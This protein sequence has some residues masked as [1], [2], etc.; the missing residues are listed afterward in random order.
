[1]LRLVLSIWMV[2]APPRAQLEPFAGELQTIQRAIAEA[3]GLG[4]YY[5]REYRSVES[6][7]WQHIPAWM[8][9]DA[10]E[11]KVSRILDVG[12]GYGTLLSLATRIYSGAHGVCW[13]MTDYLKPAVAA[14]YGLAF[15]RGNAELDPIPEPP[16]DLI[17]LTE[18][19]EHFNF[20]PVP[21][22]RKL[23]DALSPGGKLVLSTPDAAQWG[24]L[25]DFY[26]RLEDIPPPRAGAQTRDRHTWMYNKDE[27]EGVL[28]QAGFRQIKQLE[29]ARGVRGRHFNIVAY[30]PQF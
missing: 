20:H 29:Y 12:C 4:G 14:R 26:R 28:K 21:T 7:W 22:L 16:Y 10:R 23:Y 17:I 11:R 9:A 19:I 27:I 2:A 3:D 25:Y 5:D 30:K 18:V 13:D 1:M 6:M 15:R 8:R 24:R